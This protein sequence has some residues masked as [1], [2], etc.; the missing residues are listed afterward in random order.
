MM[1]PTGHF[2]FHFTSAVV[3]VDSNHMTATSSA[4]W[5]SFKTWLSDWTEDGRLTSVLIFCGRCTVVLIS[6]SSELVLPR[7]C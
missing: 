6:F 3:A 1:T 4:S 2:H 7:C 5:S